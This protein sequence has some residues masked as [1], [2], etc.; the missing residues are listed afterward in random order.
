MK[1][2]FLYLIGIV[3]ISGLL[4]SCDKDSENEKSGDF[5]ELLIGHWAESHTQGY[6]RDFSNPGN[7]EEWDKD[8]SDGSEY[9]F[10]PDGTVTNIYDNP[11]RVTGT[12]QLS[13][14]ELIIK[15]EGNGEYEQ[16]VSSINI[17]ELSESI[18]VLDRYEKNDIYEEY[19]KVMLLRIP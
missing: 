10:Y 3:L 2:R 15:F 16:N 13:E 4:V 19:D 1:K 7:N 11:N 14:N 12:W 17:V 9:I 5:K 18:L 6:Y 8:I